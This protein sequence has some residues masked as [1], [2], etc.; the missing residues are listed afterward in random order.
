MSASSQMYLLTEDRS[1]QVFGLY[2]KRPRGDALVHWRRS[3]RFRY[4][5]LKEAAPAVRHLCDLNGP[6]LLIR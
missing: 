4:S 6:R 5:D 2:L 3:G 1:P